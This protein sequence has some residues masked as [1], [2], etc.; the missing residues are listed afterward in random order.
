[1]PERGGGTDF[2]REGGGAKVPFENNV[3]YKTLK[4]ELFSLLF[5]TTSFQDVLSSFQAVAL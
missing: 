5:Q 3:L 1:M 4:A 2:S